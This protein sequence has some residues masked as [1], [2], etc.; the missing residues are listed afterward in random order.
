MSDPEQKSNS[1]VFELW[2]IRWQISGIE[3]VQA[4]SH[5]S[6]LPKESSVISYLEVETKTKERDASMEWMCGAKKVEKLGKFI[7]FLEDQ[8]EQ[9]DSPYHY[10]ITLCIKFV[11]HKEI[12]EI[13]LTALKLMQ[14]SDLSIRLTSQKVNVSTG[15]TYTFSL[16]SLSTILSALSEPMDETFSSAPEFNPKLVFCNLK[17]LKA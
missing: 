4:L 1:S 16:N 13:V 11:L 12:Q 15:D 8:K 7:Q 9:E 2:L 3:S 5:L 10:V 17:T 14:K 6:R